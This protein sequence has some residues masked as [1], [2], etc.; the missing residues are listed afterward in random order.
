[1]TKRLTVHES[2]FQKKVHDALNA[3]GR[4]TR[5]F[6]TNAGTFVLRDKRGKQLSVVEGAPD[7][8]PDLVGYVRAWGPFTGGWFLGV[9]LKSAT[10]VYTEEQQDW[11]DRIRDAGGVYAF[12]RYVEAWTLDEN[13]AAAVETVDAAVEM[14]RAR[15]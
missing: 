4:E 9:E 6:R 3:P 5:V 10:A 2:T 15:K 8:C 7:G 11:G 12:C 13:V 1:M 14:R